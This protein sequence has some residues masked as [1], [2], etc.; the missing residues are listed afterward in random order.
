MLFL[1]VVFCTY[2]KVTKAPADG[3][4]A[5]AWKDGKNLPCDPSKLVYLP[6]VNQIIQAEGRKYI[7][8]EYTQKV[9]KCRIVT[10][11]PKPTRV[12]R[13]SVATLCRQTRSSTKPTKWKQRNSPVKNK[14]KAAAGADISKEPASEANAAEG[15]DASEANAT[16]GNAASEANATEGNAASAA[17]AGADISKEPA[18]E[19][20]A[21]EAEGNDASEANAAE[22]NDASEANATEG[23]AASD[24]N[25]SVAGIS[26]TLV[27]LATR[28]EKKAEELKMRPAKDLHPVRYIP[29]VLVIQF[30]TYL[31][32]LARVLDCHLRA[33]L[34]VD[35]TLTCVC[36]ACVLVT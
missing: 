12:T 30:H 32:S 10:G 2:R 4:F 3:Q 33:Y 25:A 20:N 23:N 28:F 34:R 24:S 16:E 14:N 35:C 36:N 17:A 27:D 26:A 7:V 31:R 5:V 21:A 8:Q 19:A 18:S 9:V 13:R 29:R 11:T 1:F 6:P 22:G 15:N